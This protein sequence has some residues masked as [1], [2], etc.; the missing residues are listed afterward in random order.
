MSAVKDETVE[1]LWDSEIQKYYRILTGIPHLVLS[2]K[3]KLLV[4]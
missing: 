1:I 4:L 2:K 3:K